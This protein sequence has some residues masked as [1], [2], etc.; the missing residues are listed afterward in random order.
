M[1]QSDIAASFMKVLK[2]NTAT[3]SGYERTRY[4][5]TDVLPFD[6]LFDGH[7]LP[8]GILIE[9]SSQSG[10]GKSTLFLQICRNLCAK[11]NFAIY[12]D[13][14]RGVTDSQ[15]EGAGLFAYLDTSFFIL[16]ENVYSKLAPTL[17]ELIK[18]KPSIIII[19]SITA[20]MSSKMLS[21]TDVEKV[22][23]FT[24]SGTQSVFVKQLC[25]KCGLHGVTVVLINQQ[26]TKITKGLSKVK[27]SG[28]LAVEYYPSVR[29]NM[30]IIGSIQNSNA[31]STDKIKLPPIGAK[32]ALTTDKSRF[33][34]A[35]VRTACIYF[36]YGISNAAYIQ[37]ILMEKGF[38]TQNC[39]WFH[40]ETP[41]LD[42]KAQGL[43]ELS[44]VIRANFGYLSQ[45]VLG[46]PIQDDVQGISDAAGS[47][48][49]VKTSDTDS[50][51]GH[52]E[53]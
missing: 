40:L 3:S 32:I 16:R 29:I 9:V 22:Y 39:A 17:D 33:G 43:K 2:T 15:L 42:V 25:T 46:T 20:L 18:L 26:R 5:K 31:I 48:G 30:R 41:E 35:V 38:L 50:V 52:D 6:A 13:A 1:T 21:A 10:V 8:V 11:G 45:L 53:D 23:G 44:D 27:G 28:G 12:V 36:G 34:K 19:D 4:V 37:G 7:G 14:E 51:G 47:A 24:D 49:C